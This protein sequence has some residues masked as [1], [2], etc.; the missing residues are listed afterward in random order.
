MRET[1]E[2]V[3]RL[4]EVY[5][6]HPDAEMHLSPHAYR[7]PQPGTPEFSA[8]RLVGSAAP[9]ATIERW[10]GIGPEG[11]GPVEI[12]DGRTGRSIARINSNA[13]RRMG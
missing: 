8:E 13:R 6:A 7:S 10:D 2:L 11:F 9:E 5:H 12:L 1:D 4:H 3:R